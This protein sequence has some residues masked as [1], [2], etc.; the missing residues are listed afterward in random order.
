MSE[1]TI[2]PISSSEDLFIFILL[3]ISTFVL[4]PYVADRESASPTQMVR[5]DRLYDATTNLPV[6]PDRFLA[7]V[8]VFDGLAQIVTYITIPEQHSY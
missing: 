3:Y 8:P 6:Y 5:V 4:L 7:S 2:F 1:M